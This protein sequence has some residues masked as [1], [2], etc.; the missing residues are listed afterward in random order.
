M[1]EI[2]EETSKAVA[3]TGILIVSPSCP[4]VSILFIT[5]C[6]RQDFTDAGGAATDF[7]CRTIRETPNKGA[8]PSFIGQTDM[9][10]YSP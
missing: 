3:T 1:I 10:L 6:G 4:L 8:H 2:Y 5:P 9:L 7:F